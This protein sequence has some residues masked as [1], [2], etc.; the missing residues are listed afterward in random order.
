MD[1]LQTG[2]IA[3]VRAALT[4]QPQQL[5]P[6]F[7]LEQVA[8]IGSHNGVSTMLYYGALTC[9]IEESHPL[10]NE[11]FNE[12]CFSTITGERQMDQL[13]KI[14]AAFDENHIDYMPLKGTLLK[15]M[16]PKQEM[17]SMCDADILIRVEQYDAIIPIMQ[18]LG[19]APIKETDHELVWANKLIFLELHKRLIPSYNKDYYAYYG[20]GWKLATQKN[21]CRY[22]MTDEDQ[23]IYLFTHF[24]KHYRDSGIGIRHVVDLWVYRQNKPD[25]D[26]EYLRRELEKLSL[27]EFFVNVMDTLAVWF[28]D[29]PATDI[30]DFIT[31]IIFNSGVCGSDESR[32]LSDALKK[33][34]AAGS[35][36]TA[37][38]QGFWGMVFL[39]YDQ[40]CKKYPVLEKW[41]ILLPVMWVHRIVGAALFRREHVKFQQDRLNAM[42]EEN[43]NDYQNALN[44]VG[45][46]FNFKE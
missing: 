12:L 19:L 31:A 6:D 7:D 34:K 15:S 13:Q 43:I 44:F 40:M 9:G 27:Y 36:R 14:F 18:A 24:A 33:S 26:E 39:P 32:I 25:L 20:D 23:M 35:A 8:K 46:D 30:T 42:T 29:K 41:A 21:G 16:Y 37:K 3:L 28:A 38:F 5:P 4:G 45:L 17:R 10:Y 11:L 1:N 22:A 2:I